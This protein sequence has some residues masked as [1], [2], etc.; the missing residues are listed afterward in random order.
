MVWFCETL[1]SEDMI[2]NYNKNDK[3]GRDGIKGMRE[4]GKDG[5]RE[6]E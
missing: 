4:G 2:T 3:S 5:E 6:R 1:S